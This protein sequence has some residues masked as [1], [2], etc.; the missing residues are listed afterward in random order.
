VGREA[1]TQSIQIAIKWLDYVY[2]GVPAPQPGLGSR[3]ILSSAQEN[4]SD[5]SAG[6]LGDRLVQIFKWFRRIGPKMEPASVLIPLRCA[7]G[8][9][10]DKYQTASQQGQY[11]EQGVNHALE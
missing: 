8:R 4:K 7:S 3:T 2:N 1:A 6:H 10:K 5:N 11:D 9:E